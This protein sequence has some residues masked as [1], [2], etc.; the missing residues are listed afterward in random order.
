MKAIDG[1]R[2]IKLFIVLIILGISLY[3][4]YKIYYK[5]IYDSIAIELKDNTVI[6]YGKGKV[7]VKK[8]IKNVYLC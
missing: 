6:E 8:F 4:G 5:C 1:P 2:L 7:D 3:Y